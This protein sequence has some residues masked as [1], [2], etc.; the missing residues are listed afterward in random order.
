MPSCITHSFFI[1][2]VVAKLEQEDKKRLHHYSEHLKTYAQGPDLLYFYNYWLFFGTS[3]KIRQAGTVA[4]RHHT[5][6][7]FT[8][9]IQYILNHHLEKNPEI[10][11]FLYGSIAHYVLDITLHPYI[12]YMAYDKIKKRRISH[13]HAEIERFLDNYMI[14]SRL[15]TNPKLFKCYLECYNVKKQSKDLVQLMNTVYDKTYRIKGIGYKHLSCIKQYKTYFRL[16]RYD[17]TGIKKQIYQI[18]DAI[19]PSFFLKTR[20]FSYYIDVL[21]SHHFLNEKKEE[22]FNIKM[23][24]QI[25]HSSFEEL[26]QESIKLTVKIINKVNLVL[27]HKKDYNSLDECFLNISYST[28]LGCHPY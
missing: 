20:N 14:Q 9:I 25:Y 27:Q 13:K 7:F 10:I 6:L 1:K 3:K 28:G 23:P 12:N 26:Y 21:K 11:S 18:W 22:W 8:T 4:H 17:P 15:H 2:D 19:T 5:K 24:T 16:F